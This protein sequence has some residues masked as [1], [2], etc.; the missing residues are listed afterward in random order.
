MCRASFT[1][2]C[3]LLDLLRFSPW[4]RPADAGAQCTVTTS[5]TTGASVAITGTGSGN[6]IRLCVTDAVIRWGLYGNSSGTNPNIDTGSHFPMTAGGFAYTNLAYTTSKGTYTLVPTNGNTASVP[7]YDITVNSFSGT[8]SDT[9]TLYY[10]RTCNADNFNC[11]GSTFTDTSFVITLSPPAP[12][13]TSLTPTSGTPS[14]GTTVTLTGTGFTG[15]SG[16]TGVKFGSTNATSYTVVSNTSITAVSPA[17]SGTVDVTVT[18][19]GLT[20]ATSS[21][22]RFAYVPTVT[23][24]TPTSGGAGRRHDGDTHGHG[25]SPGRRA[26]PA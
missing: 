7:E 15:T 13:V 6:V 19:N 26:P 12:T 23:A 16:A 3:S 9:I 14:G 18:N 11:T 2:Q 17:G 21:S 22:D 24:I 25:L 8:T 4:V 5:S 10:A 20:S 1:G